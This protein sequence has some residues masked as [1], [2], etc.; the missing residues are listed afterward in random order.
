M[1]MVIKSLFMVGVVCLMS[2]ARV[3]DRERSRPNNRTEN[4]W[5]LLREAYE[6][7]FQVNTPKA[8]FAHMTES[9][10]RFI[11]ELDLN[12]VLLGVVAKNR[13]DS[14]F[15]EYAM[16]D[17]PTNSEREYLEQ[18]LDGIGF[19]WLTPGEFA[20]AISLYQA[21]FGGGKAK[22]L[23][24]LAVAGCLYRW[25]IGVAHTNAM[26]FLRQAAADLSS[27]EKAPVLRMTAALSAFHCCGDPEEI[28]H[29]FIDLHANRVAQ[30]REKFWEKARQLRRAGLPGCLYLLLGI[31]SRT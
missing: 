22:F 11:D 13:F 1:K 3:W 30:V 6:G 27:S 31:K 12:F 24:R 4:E 10:K 2:E 17:L 15:F 28:S 26:S 5:A 29:V 16:G 19:G 18:I 9:R 25:N 21:H 8:F 23:E 14:G 20:A 7:I